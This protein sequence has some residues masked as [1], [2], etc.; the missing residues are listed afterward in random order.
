MDGSEYPQS[1]LKLPFGTTKMADYANKFFSVFMRNK[2]MKMFTG[3]I[4]YLRSLIQL[5]II[6]II[7]VEPQWLEYLW[8]LGN[9]FEIWVVRAT[10]G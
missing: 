2:N 10:E 8:D 1:I 4:L 7:T 9:L 3:L 6:D 5:I